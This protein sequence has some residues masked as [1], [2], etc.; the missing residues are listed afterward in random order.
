MLGRLGEVGLQDDAG[1]RA[2]GELGLGQ[3]VERE[4][5][6][7]LARV[8]GLHVDVQVRADLLRDAQQ[9]LQA[10]SR[11]LDPAL[12]RRRTQ[13]R[14]ERGD[15]DERLTWPGLVAAAASARSVSSQ[16]CM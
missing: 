6:D 4:L 16:R 3:Q 11:A 5:G 2:L 7:R 1:A 9:V 13:Q 8:E 14:R 12:R 15:L 10:R